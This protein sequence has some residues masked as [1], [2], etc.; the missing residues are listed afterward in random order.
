MVPTECADTLHDG[1]W[2]CQPGRY[3]LP[4]AFPVP[5][6][7]PPTGKATVGLSTGE[8]RYGILAKAMVSTKPGDPPVEM[9]GETAV[10]VEPNNMPMPDFI[11]PVSVHRQKSYTLSR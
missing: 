6:G 4:F 7:L 9:L 5:V 2:Q 10:C 1:W 8:F 11:V 3:E